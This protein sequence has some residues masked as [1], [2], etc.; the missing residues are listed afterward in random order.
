LDEAAAQDF[1]EAWDEQE[2]NPKGAASSFVSLLLGGV[3]YWLRLYRTNAELTTNYDVATWD[4]VLTKHTS[5]Q[6]DAS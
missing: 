6:E 4:E 2:T 3:F 5:L 1:M